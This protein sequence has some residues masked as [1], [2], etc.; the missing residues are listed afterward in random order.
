MKFRRCLSF[1][2]CLF[3]YTIYVSTH[4]HRQSQV[5]LNTNSGRNTVQNTHAQHTYTHKIATFKYMSVGS[6]ANMHEMNPIH[7]L[8][9]AQY[10]TYI[11]VN[12]LFNQYVCNVVTIFLTFLSIKRN[13]L[14]IEMD[15]DRDYSIACDVRNIL[16]SCR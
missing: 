12:Y 15:I 8:H 13:R 16:A 5:N 4:P 6:L 9:T 2:F 14:K 11:L 7:V 1:F 3:V 10:Y